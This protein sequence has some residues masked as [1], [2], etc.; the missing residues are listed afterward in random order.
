MSKEGY[1]EFGEGSKSNACT[2]R[3]ETFNAGCT[4]MSKRAQISVDSL[5]AQSTFA[6]WIL[7]KVPD[8]AS[9]M[10]DKALHAKQPG[11]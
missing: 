6:S 8:K 10:E 5:E 9:H 3:K 2:I 1:K 7:P 4:R 11:S